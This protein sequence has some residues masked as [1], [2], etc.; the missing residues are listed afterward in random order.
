M[1]KKPEL[2]SLCRRG[3]F[4]GNLKILIVLLVM[5]LGVTAS[6]AQSVNVK[7]RVIDKN[8]DP[9]IGAS[10]I[11]VGSKGNGAV[12][13]IDGK[14]S[15]SLK[16]SSSQISFSAIGYETV[17]V[18]VEGRAVIDVEMRDD[19][20]LI[21]EFVV[22]GYG[23]LRKS[24]LTGAIASIGSEELMRGTPTDFGSGLQGKIAGV[25]VNRNDG[26]PGAGI[27]ITIRG[28]NSTS[29]ST[30]FTV[31]FRNYVK[32][33]LLAKSLNEILTVLI[34]KIF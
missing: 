29:T 8:G 20:N 14:Y 13:D 28:A 10:V 6:F 31:N 27:S 26:A 3:L 21:D 30:E 9:V 5:I 15:I 4:E 7:G 24:D 22:V 17:S 2:L 11:E 12:T 18:S 32:A 34:K 33:K 25:Q 23:K 19:V 16:S 1:N